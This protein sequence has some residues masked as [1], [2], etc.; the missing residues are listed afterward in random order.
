L[1]VT[2]ISW[3]SR[4]P[5]PHGVPAKRHAA[6]LADAL[7]VLWKQ[8]VGTV[9]WFRVVDQP[10]VPNYETTNQS[11]LYFLSGRAKPAQRAFAFPFACE[12]G[13]RRRYR[14]WGVAPHRFGKVRVQL[15]RAGGGWKTVARA[16]PGRDRVFTAQRVGAAN[17]LR[18]IQGT[19]RSNTCALDARGK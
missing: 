11:G 7:Y 3:D 14:T 13:K 5:D 12:R 1:A 4:A 9:L 2:E 15:R 16:R 19:R 17:Q 18:A 8:H 10:A 6:W